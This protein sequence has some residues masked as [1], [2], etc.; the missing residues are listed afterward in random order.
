MPALIPLSLSAVIY[1]HFLTA[2]KLASQLHFTL[3]ALYWPPC[4]QWPSLINLQGWPPQFLKYWLSFTFSVPLS[5]VQLLSCV[6]LFATSSTEAHQASLSINNSRSL[7]K[8][9]PIESMIPSNHLTLCHPFS[10]CLQSFPALGSFLRSWLSASGGQS[11]G[12]SAS[13]SVLPMSIQDS[14]PLGWLIWSPCS[15]RNF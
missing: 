13:G 2:A 11:N 1:P 10:S 3:E 4:L 9:M 15:P 12:A 8:L 14:L 5:S 6:R 7:L